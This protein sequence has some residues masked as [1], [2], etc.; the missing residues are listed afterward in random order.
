MSP[1]VCMCDTHVLYL[2][3]RFTNIPPSGSVH[4]QSSFLLRFLFL[5]LI[6]LFPLFL[7]LIY[8]LIHLYILLFS[9]VWPEIHFF[10]L[11]TTSLVLS[12]PASLS[13]VLSLSL[14]RSYK[15]RKKN[16]I[17]NWGGKEI[18]NRKTY[19]YFTSFLGS[20]LLLNS[21]C[22]V[23]QRLVKCSHKTEKVRVKF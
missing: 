9:G 17:K 16:T 22:N 19:D 20:D 5:S 13:F 7:F 10:S 2:L 18:G 23:L 21:N 6:P 3:D 4:L 12:F 14:P 11:L 15:I 8:L 1:T